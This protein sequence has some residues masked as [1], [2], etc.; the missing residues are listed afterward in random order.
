[1]LLQVSTAHADRYAAAAE[2]IATATFS[3]AT[4]RARVL[5]CDPA[6]ADCLKSYIQ[7]LGRRLYRRPLGTD[8]VTGFVTLAGAAA[9]PANPNMGPQTILQAMLFSPYFLYR[10]Q[11][12]VADA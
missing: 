10:L 7:K 3:D 11:I 12:G 6:G 8:E 9:D 5:T 4:R 1:S 2:A